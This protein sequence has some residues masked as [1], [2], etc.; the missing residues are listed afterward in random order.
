MEKS[1]AQMVKTPTKSNEIPITKPNLITKR[2]VTSASYGGFTL[3]NIAKKKLSAIKGY[4]IDDL[5]IER[6][7]ADL[8]AIIKELG[9]EI[10]AGD[11]YG[12]KM[13]IK[14]ITFN[15]NSNT[16]TYRIGSTDGLERILIFSNDKCVFYIDDW[17]N[18]R[19]KAQFK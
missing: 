1:W 12:F 6:D 16:E 2:V 17:D 10:V 18:S 3:S 11:V 8:I 19:K 9:E 5:N 15:L 14:I 13:K 4:A 7:D